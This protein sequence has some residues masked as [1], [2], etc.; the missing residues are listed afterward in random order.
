MSILHSNLDPASD[1]AQAN[2]TGHAELVAELRERLATAALGGPEASRDRHV[3]RGKLLP[4]ERVARLLDEGSPFLEVAPLAAEG[5]YG[6]DSPGA[7]IIT[8]VGLVHGRAVMVVCNDA[9]VKGGTYYP[10]TV[11]KHL[12]A[13]EVAKEQRLRASTSSTRAARS[14]RCRTT[15]SP[16]A[17]T[18]AAS[19]STRPSSRRCASRSSPPCSAP[20]PRAAPT[21]PR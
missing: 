16:I 11:K 5:L 21:C 14:C 10:M 1:A 18:S 13:Q 2:L 17:S 8:G 6:G 15:C 3:A 19:S 4:R 12:R 7:G 9:T 20:A